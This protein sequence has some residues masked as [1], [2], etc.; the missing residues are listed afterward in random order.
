MWKCQGAESGTKFNEVELED[1]EWNDYDEK[2]RPSFTRILTL[3]SSANVAECHV[4]SI[5][6]GDFRG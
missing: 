3:M 6:R 1:G 2:A 5:T 4:G